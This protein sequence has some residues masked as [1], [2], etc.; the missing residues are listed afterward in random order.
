MYA[1]MQAL[2]LV[3][4]HLEGCPARERASAARARFRVPRA[5]FRVPRAASRSKSC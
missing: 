3:N 4:D 1:M 5:R 2:G